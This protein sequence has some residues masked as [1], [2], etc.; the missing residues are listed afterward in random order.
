MYENLL[1]SNENKTTALNNNLRKNDQDLSEAESFIG[2]H[3]GG[4][5]YLHCGGHMMKH[6]PVLDGVILMGH[7]EMY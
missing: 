6:H 4:K 7:P 5:V 1:F 3:N 2:K